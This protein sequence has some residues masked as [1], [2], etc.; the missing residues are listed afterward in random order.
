M[1][2]MIIRF[3][4]LYGKLYGFTCVPVEEGL[5]PEHRGELFADPLEQLLDGCRVT[6]VEQIDR[7]DR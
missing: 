5:P 1:N 4:W 2:L 7:L 6:Y 3:S